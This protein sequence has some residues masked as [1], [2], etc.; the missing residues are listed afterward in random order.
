[1]KTMEIKN[2][3]GEDIIPYIHW[4]CDVPIR[5]QVDSEST[6]SIL[7]NF[8]LGNYYGLIGYVNGEAIGLMIYQN[9]TKESIAFKFLH[10]PKHMLSFHMELM[11]YLNE[12]R[13]RNFV[14]ESFHGPELWERMFPG[15]V[16][17]LRS[18]YTFD[19]AGLFDV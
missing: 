5:K 19:V 8:F 18:T 15:A 16:K 12:Y 14:F 3:L 4:F 10:S 9:L 17:R 6:K 7:T 1:M 11:K 2:V 13:I